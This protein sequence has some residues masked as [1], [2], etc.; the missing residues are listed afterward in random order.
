MDGDGHAALPEA[1]GRVAATLIS[2]TERRIHGQVTVL[3]LVRIVDRQL[4]NAWE[5]ASRFA[6]L[7]LLD[8]AYPPPPAWIE[9]HSG[10]GVG[11]RRD[12]GTGASPSGCR[13]SLATRRRSQ[14]S[15]ALRPQQLRVARVR[16][17]LRTRATARQG[18][19]GRGRVGAGR[20][21]RGR[22]YVTLAR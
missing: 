21:A 9:R 20:R 3:A 12:R 6:P 17:P 22:T 1:G 11:W 4:G 19:V 2:R 7:A 10:S 8:C 14:A 13:S 16:P 18:R 15:L 5:N